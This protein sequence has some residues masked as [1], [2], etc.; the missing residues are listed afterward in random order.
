MRRLLITLALCGLGLGLGLGS[1]SHAQSPSPP[2]LPVEPSAPDYLFLVDTSFSMARQRLTL[3]NALA[4]LIL[5]GVHGQIRPGQII[6]VC[7]FNDIVHA[8]RLSGELWT[9]DQ[10]QGL[11]QR[12]VQLVKSQRFEKQTRL[13]VAVEEMLR[14]IQ[15]APALTIFLFSDGDERISNTPFDRTLNRVYQEQGPASRRARKP[16]ITTFVARAGRLTDWSVALAG[17]TITIPGAPSLAVTGIP[18]PVP[19]AVS[20]NAV[21]SPE[22]PPPPPVSILLPTEV[23][24]P[25]PSVRPPSVLSDIAHPPATIP[26]S[27]SAATAALSAHDGN[28]TTS[29]SSDTSASSSISSSALPAPSQKLAR[30]SAT[31]ETSS[32]QSESP[33]QSEEK[34]ATDP[35]PLP[36]GFETPTPPV[37]VSSREPSRRIVPD[38]IPEPNSSVAA[39]ESSSAESP[40]G[41][42]ALPKTNSPAPLLAALA[43]L[44]LGVGVLYRHFRGARSKSRCSLISQS[45]DRPP[46]DGPR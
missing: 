31:P 26:P 34:K 6:S 44:L 17:E 15:T 11:A 28:T 19:P 35:P 3:T 16:I 10:S 32:A 33:V 46:E 45:L 23:T 7:T 5:S 4:S 12:A 20:L 13:E 8:R 22:L 42:L 27:I 37:S 1:P 38:L 30:D 2:V 21:R 9:P 14:A 25:A 41:V 43:L 40:M 18:S 29:R 39:V 24:S 36:A